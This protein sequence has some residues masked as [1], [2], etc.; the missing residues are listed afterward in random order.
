MQY[1]YQTPGPQGTLLLSRPELTWPIRP[2]DDAKIVK[3]ELRLNGEPLAARYENG[4]VR[5]TPA[6]P[7]APGSYTAECRVRFAPTQDDARVS[8]RFTVAPDATPSPPPPTAWAR[9]ALQAANQ[10]RA[11]LGL[12]PLQLDS[13]LCGAAQAH[14]SYLHKN[15]VIGHG[16]VPG[17]PGFTGDNPLARAQVFGYL[18]SLAE[19][20]SF[21]D[22]SPEKIVRGLFA[23]PYHRLPFLRP[24]SLVFGAGN[25]GRSSGLLF[26]GDGVGGT[27]VSP[28]DGET[29]VPTTW[30]NDES[31]NP[32]RFWPQAPRVVGYP[33]VLAHYAGPN[34]VLNVERASL[35]TSAGAE[36]PCLLN[37][38][39][40]DTELHY[41]CL[42]I[43]Q[44]PLKP[45]T[46][47]LVEVVAREVTRRWRFTTTGS[48]NDADFG[49][50]DLHPD[51]L[52]LLGTV[53]T[54]ERG[55]GVLQL[56]VTRAQGYAAPEKELTKPLTVTLRLTPSTRFVS[57]SN[58]SGTVTLTPGLP[59]AVIVP[60]GPLDRPLNA[61]SVI[62]LR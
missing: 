5:A 2:Q 28:Y 30:R 50:L 20:V 59:L 27:T 43:P 55:K 58:R 26:G 3:I 22:G 51:D 62:L 45:N 36:V 13:R 35:K 29:G 18:A 42:L 19:D 44:A 34:T 52:K 16:E 4:A 25:T 14:A 39:A 60:N 11:G 21:A 23:A 1:A 9:E 41:A 46:T 31:P 53:V 57:E 38:P 56:R 61:R 54:A 40:R 8:W 47:Y 48:P 7:L 15:N 24:G 17:K 6:T 10:L 37:T 49:P 12:A 32:T 33:I